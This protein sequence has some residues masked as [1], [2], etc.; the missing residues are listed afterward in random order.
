MANIVKKTMKCGILDMLCPHFCRGCGEIGAV[1]CE[2][3]KN[4]MISEKINYCPN[5]ERVI[6]GEKCEKCRLPFSATF[7]IGWRDELIGELVEEYK[8]QSV[9]ALGKVLADI[10][11]ESLPDLAGEVVVVPMPTINQ[12]VRERGI[13]HT[14]EVAK[15]LAKKRGWKV[16][17]VVLRA[18]NT[19]Q[20]GANEKQRALQAR[21]AYKIEQELDS[22]KVYVIF[23]DVWT[24]G[25]SMKEVGKLMKENG[26]KKVVAV[27]LA[28]N[29]IGKKPKIKAR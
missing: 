19:V 2:C 5:C 26:A 25:A 24:T 6:C 21:E 20:V 7:M 4:N 1:F 11:D 28:V 10:L 27:V 12:H 29:R 14:F 22:E 23:D 17:K 3:C 8:Y 16:E 13:D 9:R 18:K 15:K